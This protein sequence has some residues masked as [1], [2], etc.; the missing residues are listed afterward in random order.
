MFVKGELPK[1]TKPQRAPK[2]E[3]LKRMIKKLDKV[4]KRGY[5]SPG[6]VVSLTSYFAVPK[7][8]LDIRLIYD[9]SS[10]GLNDALWAP[11]FWMPTSETAV[12]VISFYSYLFDSDIGECFLN[13]PNDKRLR[14]Y[15]GV[16][17]TPFR[18]V[19]N[20]RPNFTFG[21]LWE[22][23]NRGFMGCKSSPYNSVR[24]L[25]LADEFCRGF[26]KGK[27]NPMRWDRARLNLPGSN[28]FD[29][30]LPRVYKW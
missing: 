1:N 14:K 5:I 28:T 18:G 17:L 15:C 22:A 27:T 8:E 2:P 26:R 24:Y 6:L 11:S 20:S 4:L 13:F 23:W 3:D 9:G 19:L 7:G 12:R 29:P 30:R 10:S 21:L 16:D 25:Y